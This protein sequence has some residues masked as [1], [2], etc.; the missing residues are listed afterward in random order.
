LRRFNLLIS[1]A[2]QDGFYVTA[3][4]R[5]A[6]LA[7]ALA[8]VIGLLKGQP[9]GAMSPLVTRS[10]IRESRQW[11][12]R[13]RVPLFIQV[14]AVLGALSTNVGLMLVTGYALGDFVVTGP[15]IDPS[16]RPPVFEIYTL[17]NLNVAQCEYLRI[18]QL[19]S[20]VSLFLLAV[21][22]TLLARLLAPRAR[23]AILLPRAISNAAHSRAGRVVRLALL[24][25]VQR[26]WLMPGL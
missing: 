3:W 12:P 14:S 13:Y 10:L 1:E 9:I 8:F 22:P 20:Y 11:F 4:P 24:A 2:W 6:L 5:V 17:G 7:S 26:C 18:P 23:S 15:V 21:V 25:L 19:L 16:Y